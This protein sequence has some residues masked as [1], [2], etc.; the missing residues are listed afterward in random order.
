MDQ[1]RLNRKMK[2]SDLS[3]QHKARS[4]R[5]LDGPVRLSPWILATRPRTLSLSV[6]P[7]VVGG[8]LAWAI[9]GQVYWPALLAALLGA[10]L[11]HLGTNLHNDATGSKRGGDGPDRFGPPRATAS[12]LL[13]AAAVNASA[14]ACFAAAALIGCYLTWIGGWPILL[15]G[16]ASILS[17]WAYNGGPL[18][19]AYTPFGELFVL[20][21]FGIG[22]V[23]GTY[24]LGAAHL[25]TIAVEAGSALGFFAAA[26]LLVN[27]RRDVKA[28]ARVGRQTLAI[29][30]GPQVTNWIYTAL[31]LAPFALLVL[32]GSELPRGHAWP[33]LMSLPLVALLINQFIHETR[34]RGLNRILGQTVQVQALFGFLLCLGLVL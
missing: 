19:V 26:V 5:S 31:M 30:A 22:A 14:V 32:V 3:M 23:C 12:G 27:N 28:D 21:F 1:P 6:T 17:G 24:W 11:I 20:F 29:V 34:E 4:L 25:N 7:V 15:L 16:V 2:T 13:D 9:E 10:I 18:P 33:A 8:A